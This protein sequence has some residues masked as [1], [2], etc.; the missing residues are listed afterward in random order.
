MCKPAS[1]IVTKDKVFWSKRTDSHSEIIKEHNLCE[2]GV[3]GVN[4]VPVEITPPKDDL[5]L[6]LKQWKFCVDFADI[7]REL[8]EWW[9]QE[10]HEAMC[11]LELKEWAKVK[12]KGWRVKEAFNP[13][14]PLLIKA[15]KDI[16]LLQLLKEWDSVSD[17]VYASVYD[18]VYDSVS[19]SVSAYIGSLFPNI[20]TWKY[21][22]KKNPWSS[23]RKLWLAGYVPS[24]DGKT[25][26]L[27]TG[28]K[29]EIVLEITQ[30]ELRK[31]G[32]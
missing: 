2:S 25:W 7:L 30:D 8:P 28:K 24:F 19:D 17:S 15:R 9:D 20:K 11:R 26:R 1:F 6:P 13:V 10:K 3:R 31:A 12:L 14:N 22:D 27:H 4:V 21:T 18:S 29:A 23:L 5:S 32:E 16:D